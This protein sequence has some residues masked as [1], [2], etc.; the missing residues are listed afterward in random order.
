MPTGRAY[1]RDLSLPVQVVNN[2]LQLLR[3]ALRTRMCRLIEAMIFPRAAKPMIPVAAAAAAVAGSTTSPAISSTVVIVDPS[4]PRPPSSMMMPGT[5]SSS[6]EAFVLCSPYASVSASR[7]PD[8]PQSPRGVEQSGGGQGGGA[9]LPC[10]AGI[11]EVVC[12]CREGGERERMQDQG[13]Q[14]DVAFIPQTEPL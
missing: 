6:P 2:L 5:L 10:I 8:P 1:G 7:A 9:Q 4:P 11:R 3:K 13:V 14:R 12:G